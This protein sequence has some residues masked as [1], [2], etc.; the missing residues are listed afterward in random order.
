MQDLVTTSV[1]QE[2]HLAALQERLGDS[3]RTVEQ[4]RMLVKSQQDKIAQF[5]NRE[6]ELKFQ[7]DTIAVESRSLLVCFAYIICSLIH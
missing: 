5:E 3:M 4:F 1:I 6:R 7:N 2:K